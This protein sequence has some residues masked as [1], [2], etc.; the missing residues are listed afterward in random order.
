MVI[1]SCQSIE[2]DEIS[3]KWYDED[4]DFELWISDSLSLGYSRPLDVLYLYKINLNN[5]VI[6]FE[7]IESDI[8]SNPKYSTKII[9]LT[10]NSLTTEYIEQTLS[11]KKQV[12]SLLSKKVPVIHADLTKNGVYLE[13]FRKNASGKSIE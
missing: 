6:N 9:E 2:T 12:L 1:S 13:V 8:S 5:N 3:G 4:N 10:D 7:L 11:E